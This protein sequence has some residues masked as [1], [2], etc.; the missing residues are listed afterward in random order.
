MK[1]VLASS[2]LLALCA[3]ASAN[4]SKQWFNS[5]GI[6]HDSF[7]SENILMASSTY[8]FAPQ[9][10]AGV[11]DD[12]GYL[13]TDS[14][15]GISYVNGKHDKVTNVNA[16]GFY[17]NFFVSASSNDLLDG[18]IDE[19]AFGY[20]YNELKMSV[21]QVKESFSGDRNWWVR[22]QYNHQ[23]ND[24]DYIGVTADLSEDGDGWGISAR[25]FK[26]L[27]NGRFIAVDAGINDTDLDFITARYYLNEQWAVGAGLIDS[28][29]QIEAK[30]FYNDTYQVQLTH[31]NLSGGNLTGINFVAQF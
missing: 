13:N 29:P 6:V 24:S 9:Q 8:F 4:D 22:G 18:E 28:N 27:N 25:Y 20:L 1:K 31:Q 26:A 7:D 15:V 10:H 19:I 17:N 14:S 2:L 30:Y 11:W 5:A 16:E 23:I 12:F 3:T 21:R